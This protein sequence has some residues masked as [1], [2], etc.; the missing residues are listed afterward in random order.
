MKRFPQIDR[1]FTALCSVMI[2]SVLTFSCEKDNLQDDF[3]RIKA[4]NLSTAS[5]K[6]LI[7]YEEDCS[8]VCIEEGSE[9]YYA[10]SDSKTGSAG[11]NSKSVSYQA[12]NTETQFV[13]EVLYQ[14]TSGNSGTKADITIDIDGNV[15]LFEDVVSGT[16]ISHAINLPEGWQA[17]NVINFTIYQEGLSNPIS[18]NENYSLIG[19]CSSE[20][21]ESFSYV[22]NE[23]GSY[24]FTYISSEDLESAE[25]KF[26]CPHITSFE[27]LDDKTYTV[28][29]GNSHGSPTV[30]TW[31]G[32]IE[33]CTEITFTLSFEADCEQTNSGKA[34]MFT[35]FKV[36][37]VS[38]KGSNKNITYQ[39]PE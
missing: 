19:V 6:T 27:A 16:T 33:A 12:Y 3:T 26:T 39:C 31:S 24:T 15:Q 10:I 38:K 4:S 5:L 23:D 8:S 30:L 29:P 17:C 36:N 2:L 7:A 22:E 13:V 34:N 18:F 1:F 28:N 20:C 25:V 32:D 21:E 11:P 37:E 14:I 35:D 9:S